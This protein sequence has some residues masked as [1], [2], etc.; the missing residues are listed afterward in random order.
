MNTQKI[1]LTNSNNSK[2]INT[3]FQ[4]IPLSSNYKRNSRFKRKKINTKT[5]LFSN[6]S[7]SIN[8]NIK[9]NVCLSFKKSTLKTISHKDF[10]N[11]IPIQNYSHRQFNNYSK[12]EFSNNKNFYNKYKSNNSIE[13]DLDMMKMQMSCDL[14]THKINQIKNKVQDLQE[15]SRNEDKVLLNKNKDYTSYS[16]IFNLSKHNQNSF[17]VNYTEKSFNSPKIENLERRNNTIN[18]LSHGNKNN[19]INHFRNNFYNKVPFLNMNNYQKYHPNKNA[20]KY[21]L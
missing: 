15:S 17:I 21:I 10:H 16:E 20:L 6:D 19:N 1:Y 5:A 18:V 7:Q 14:I 8:S 11:N 2:Y 9:D 4:S 13:K 12:N 3:K